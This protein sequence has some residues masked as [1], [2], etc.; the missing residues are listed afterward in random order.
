[1]SVGFVNRGHRSAANR[2]LAGT[3]QVPPVHTRPAL[4]AG[5]ESQAALSLILSPYFWDTDTGRP[6]QIFAESTFL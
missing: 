2:N 6:I 4:Q 3:H 5:A 1:M